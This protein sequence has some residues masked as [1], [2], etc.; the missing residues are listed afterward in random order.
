LDAAAAEGGDRP[1]VRANI[2]AMGHFELGRVRPDLYRANLVKADT[3]RRV[4][5]TFVNGIVGALAVLPP[6]P[7]GSGGTRPPLEQARNVMDPLTAL[8]IPAEQS[9][10]APL[11]VCGRTQR[12][13]DGLTRYDVEMFPSR[14]ET[15]MLDRMPVTAVVCR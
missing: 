13:F 14:V 12:V 15:I 1:G 8:A 7:G 6:G 2:E 9:G 11:N 3:T 5:M 10:T 4:G